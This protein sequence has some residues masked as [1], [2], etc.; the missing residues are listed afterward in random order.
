MAFKMKG[1][2]FK[3]SLR[4]KLRMANDPSKENTKRHNEI[5]DQQLLD[6]KRNMEQAKYD[7]EANP[8]VM[9]ARDGIGAFAKI[10]TSF[11][12]HDGTEHP[13]LQP[14]ENPD[15]EITTGEKKGDNSK[16]RKMFVLIEKLTD[17][18][19]RI[20]F[21]NE[22]ANAQ[23]KKKTDQQKKDIAKL[24]IAAKKYR[25]QIKELKKKNKGKK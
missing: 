12:K 20:S 18:E 22:D 13:P 3:Q 21:I 1:F 15:T 14:S 17:V 10:K 19:D 16:D 5:R 7:Y 11:Y 25:Q 6:S 4:D 2:P 9:A 23:G 8:E 24:K